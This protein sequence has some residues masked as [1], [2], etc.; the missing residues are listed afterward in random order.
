MQD[1]YRLRFWAATAGEEGP[2]RPR[3]LEIGANVGC[4]SLYAA[5]VMGMEVMAVEPNKHAAL[6]LHYNLAMN[7]L[8]SQ[9]RCGFQSPVALSPFI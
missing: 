4:W 3:L 6:F 9:V 5:R 2:M 7:Q 1:T 8:Q